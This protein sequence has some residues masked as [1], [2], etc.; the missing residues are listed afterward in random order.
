ML[1]I[2]YSDLAGRPLSRDLLHQWRA[3]MDLLAPST[4]NVRLSAARNG[5]LGAEEAAA[6]TAIPKPAQPSESP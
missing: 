6:L 3:S 2:T 4:V 5:M 1:S